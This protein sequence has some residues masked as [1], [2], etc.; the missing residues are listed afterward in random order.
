LQQALLDAESRIDARGE[1]PAEQRG[2]LFGLLEALSAAEHPRAGFLRRARSELL[3]ARRVLPLLASRTVEYGRCVEVLQNAM[4]ALRG[5]F[6]M[7]T[8]RSQN[9]ALHTQVIDMLQ[10][11]ED[12]Y[13]R[14]YAGMAV[15]AAVNAVLFDV[16]LQAAS[17][18]DLEVP[19]D[20]WTACFYASLVDA[21]AACWEDLTKSD[22]AKRRAFWIDYLHEVIPTAWEVTQEIRI[23]R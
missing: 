3:C 15:F 18:P 20:E 12:A 14:V 23:D 21:G 16:D 1:L 9:G 13:R 17:A 22:D 7:E 19:P 5:Q 4:Q 2:E 6:A 10:E 11:G 8:L